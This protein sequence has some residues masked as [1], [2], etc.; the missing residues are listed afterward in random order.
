MKNL[1]STMVMLLLAIFVV[2]CS[3]SSESS[4]SEDASLDSSKSETSS[5]S[6]SDDPLQTV[7]EN[8]PSVKNKLMGLPKEFQK[9]VYVP[10]M[11]T[12]P[13]A[14]DSVSVF[15]MAEGILPPG[16]KTNF[17]ITLQS[18]NSFPSIHIITFDVD[19][20]EPL[21]GNYTNKIKLKNDVQGFYTEQEKITE[22]SWLNSN[23]TIQYFVQYKRGLNKEVSISKEEMKK[24]ANS[25]ISQMK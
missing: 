19:G 22:I 17:D 7:L 23:E 4:N 3:P 14:V 16:V 21:F 11:N 15:T 5:S 25:M 1:R 6:K 2:G 13:F 9:S 20:Q 24:I 18:K 10:Q 12:I 8:Y